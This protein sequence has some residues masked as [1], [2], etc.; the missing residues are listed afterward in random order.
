MSTKTTIFR[1]KYWMEN[2]RWHFWIDGWYR[3]EDG[4]ESG[5]WAY[6]SQDDK[7]EGYETETEM[8]SA[9]N[10]FMR[11]EREKGSDGN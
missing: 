7:P 1:P 5:G 3:D 6:G 4:N 9:A 8:K 11:A 2:S 10:A